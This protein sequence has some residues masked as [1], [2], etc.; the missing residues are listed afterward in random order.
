[1]REHH[2]GSDGGATAPA[3][4]PEAYD[5]RAPGS[6][7]DRVPREPAASS[8]APGSAPRLGR[9]APV[10]VADVLRGGR[11]ADLEICREDRERGLFVAAWRERGRHRHAL[12]DA[13]R[14]TLV[15]FLTGDRIAICGTGAICDAG[16]EPAATPGSIVAGHTAVLAAG[17][18]AAWSCGGPM[19]YLLAAFP[20][21]FVAGGDLDE[22]EGFC[23]FENDHVL[24]RL[25]FVLADLAARDERL[26]SVEAWGWSTVLGRHV[27]RHL[28]ARRGTPRDGRAGAAAAGNLRA[29]VD[30]IDR[31]LQT[32]LSVPRLAAVAGVSRAKFVR[33]FR[34][35]TGCAPHRFIV[36]RRISKARQL[37]AS[38]Q[39]SLT[40]VAYAV[41]F[42]SQSHL[43]STFHRCVGATPG[44]YREALRR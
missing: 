26:D 16:G 22:F 34:S 3:R 27:A 4:R 1:M 30:F 44:A 12:H 39:L 31:N 11:V 41:G 5:D 6:R 35:A 24:R 40:E 8:G 42:S 13:D 43:T 29:V 15:F 10:L 25:G 37:L 19:R 20:A 2:A 33:L 21:S 23:R 28:A 32:P 7:R 17:T 9:D 18:R 14:V 36:E 38:S